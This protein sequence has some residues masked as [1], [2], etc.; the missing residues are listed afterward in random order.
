[1]TE[2]TELLPHC[3]EICRR[4]ENIHDRLTQESWQVFND[5]LWLVITVGSWTVLL[6]DFELLF[7]WTLAL[8]GTRTGVRCYGCTF[9]RARDALQLTADATEPSVTSE[10]PSSDNYLLSLMG[11][12]IT[13]GRW[14][15]GVTGLSSLTVDDVCSWERQPRLLNLSS[16]WYLLLRL[17]FCFLDLS[18]FFVFTSWLIHSQY[19]FGFRQAKYSACWW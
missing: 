14:F 2:E 5:W 10:I 19:D 11:D 16:V 8:T 1:M 18:A 17:C 3:F 15:V 9:W 13:A 6:T 12:E 7:V 4:I